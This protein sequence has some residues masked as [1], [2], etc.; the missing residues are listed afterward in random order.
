MDTLELKEIA[1]IHGLSRGMPEPDAARRALLEGLGRGSDVPPEVEVADGISMAAALGAPGGAP[2]ARRNAFAPS[3]LIDLRDASWPGSDGVRKYAEKLAELINGVDRRYRYHALFFAASPLWHSMFPRATPPADARLPVHTAF[4]RAEAAA[5][6]APL[7]RC[8]GDGARLAGRFAFL[9]VQSVQELIS[10]SRKPR[11]LWA[12]SW[13]VSFLLWGAISG[14]VESQGPD[15]ALRPELSLNHFYISWLL[16]RVGPGE[17]EWLSGLA[18]AFAL[19]DGSPWISM[20]GEKAYLLLPEGTGDVA[21][22][23]RRGFAE[24]WKA[25]AEELPDPEEERLRGYAEVARR[26]PPFELVV[27][28][29]D[30]GEFLGRRGF[31]A[32]RCSG[33]QDPAY[34]WFMS[35]LIGEAEEGMRLR[36]KLAYGAASPDAARAA[37][38]V[39]EGG[40]ELCTA[41]GLVPAAY[42]RNESDERRAI[43]DEERLCPYCTVRRLAMDWYANALRRMGMHVEREPG[44][45]K[46]R[47]S[48]AQLALADFESALN[49]LLR[50]RGIPPIELEAD[51]AVRLLKCLS[52][53]GRCDDP[54]RGL[55][56][57]A[58]KARTLLRERGNLYYAIIRA[59][60]DFMG[61]VLHGTLRDAD[62]SEL[63]L[64]S[65][66]RLL[67]AADARP[68]ADAY[69][70]LTGD[71]R[72]S[73]PVPQTPLYVYA[74]S[75]ALTVQAVLD[76]SLLRGKGALPIY[77]GGDDVLALAP[78]RL[79]GKWIPLELVAEG[80]AGYWAWPRGTPDGFKVIGDKG[81]YAVHDSLRSYGRSYS[82]Y[83]AHYK[84]PLAAAIRI[85][86]DLLER[87]DE[88]EGA[89]KDALFVASGRGFGERDVATAQLSR[90]AS[91]DLS[92]VDVTRGLLAC[93][94]GGELSSNA[95][96]DLLGLEAMGYADR[97]E[98]GDEL[99]RK[100]IARALERN[101]QRGGC[102]DLVNY[103]RPPCADAVRSK[104]SHDL[105]LFAALAAAH[106]R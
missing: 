28:T 87:K 7:V 46:L 18:E 14:L 101:S 42:G 59:D 77:V 15:A 104:C 93:I 96:N 1:Y 32:L 82:I 58:E 33:A 52:E 30:V 27:R 62:G 79:D 55:G 5:V 89:W 54:L 39:T 103:V 51:L 3:A 90:G 100:M 31:P 97:L 60:G 95:P 44:V 78:V 20:M 88:L 4:E 86:A 81:G 26:E 94:D 8:E 16:G 37:I 91:L 76:A 10:Y 49:N 6:L 64:E 105:L 45:L 40:Y 70:R 35:L 43:D 61:R 92:A 69:R 25:L 68:L 83:I 67:G 84:D 22:A 17:Q 63:D 102:A 13:M 48:T 24:A 57:V 36:Y 19:Y 29:V 21:E 74:V 2:P 73:I 23:A 53:G 56:D 12:A 71:S 47:E 85:S 50:E 65:Y 80:R 75:R 38:E 66:A 41:C 9:E 98:A 34:A 72:E 106:L 11:D 99:Y